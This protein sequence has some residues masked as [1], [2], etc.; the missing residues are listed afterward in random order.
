MS[1]IMKSIL[2]FATKNTSMYIKTIIKRAGVKFDIIYFIPTRVDVKHLDKESLL[3]P[4]LL[5]IVPLPLPFQH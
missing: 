5:T 1:N 2:L 4:I 3:P